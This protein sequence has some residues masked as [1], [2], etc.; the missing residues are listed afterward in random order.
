MIDLSKKRI[1]V[2]GG[3]GF[4]GR[5]I[6]E[7]LTQWGANVFVPESRLY[8]LCRESHAH[9]MLRVARP[10]IVIHCAAKV[11]GIGLNKAK[12]AELFYDNMAMGLLLMNAAQK[13][14]IEKFVQLGTICS[15]PKITPIPFQEKD[16]WNGYPEETN[17]PY[18]IAKRAL[19]TYGQALRKQYGFNVINLLPVNLYGPRDHFDLETCHVIPAMIRKFHEAKEAQEPNVT[20]W[21]TGQASREF[22]YVV[23][24]ARAIVAATERYD[25]ET[26]VNIGTGYDI[27]I[28]NLA[29]LIAQRVEYKGTITFDPSMPD[30]QPKRCL[31]TDLA[32]EKFR[33]L[34]KTSLVD[35]L[36]STIK[37]YEENLCAK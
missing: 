13:I 17:A 23:D 37:W 27:S 22:L 31:N 34:S 5:Y 15:Y 1:C 6:V 24:A 3:Q 29:Q 25:E 4:L 12:P 8:D 18:G 19:I 30:G 10:D 2:T 35:G 21:G 20:F 9:M 36:N 7:E 26:P 32:Y 16:L 33:F 14:G 28:K 11:G